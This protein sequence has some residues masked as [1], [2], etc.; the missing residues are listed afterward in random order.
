MLTSRLA[1]LQEVRNR[2]LNTPKTQQINDLFES[3]LGISN[4]SKRW[5]WVNMS[6][7]RAGEKLDG[8]VTLRGEIAHRGGAASSVTKD[9]VSDYY[10]HIKRLVQ[11]TERYV[12]QVIKRATGTTPWPK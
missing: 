9:H 1:R 11:P 4:I 12:A 10:N 3:A 2:R 6:A 7:T 8:F 5:N